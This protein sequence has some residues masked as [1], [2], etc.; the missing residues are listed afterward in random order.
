MADFPTTTRELLQ[1]EVDQGRKQ[2]YLA[3]KLGIS[4]AYLCQILKGKKKA[5]G[6]MFEFADKLGV[7]ILDR[8]IDVDQWENKYYKLLEEYKIV[9]DELLEYK[10]EWNGQERRSVKKGDV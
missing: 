6:R 3:G 9:A 4:E 5:A 7:A 8:T 2:N 10:R 1:R